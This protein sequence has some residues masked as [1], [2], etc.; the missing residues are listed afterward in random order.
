VQALLQYY[1]SI[2]IK[3]SPVL[4]QVGIKYGFSSMD[5]AI[6]STADQAFHLLSVPIITI[7]T[8][9]IRRLAISSLFSWVKSATM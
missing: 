4:N 8:H 9:S 7:I 1:R 3:K 2:T 6:A 5:I